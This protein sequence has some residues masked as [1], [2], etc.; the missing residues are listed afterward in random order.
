MLVCAFV[1][2]IH[3]DLLGSLPQLSPKKYRSD[4]RSSLFNPEGRP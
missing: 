3:G 1:R 4:S 2:V